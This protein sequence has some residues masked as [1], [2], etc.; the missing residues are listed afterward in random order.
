MAGSLPD[1]AQPHQ[2]PDFWPVSYPFNKD[3]QRM[4]LHRKEVEDVL[5]VRSD[6]GGDTGKQPSK[7]HHASDSRAASAW[8]LPGS[9]QPAKK[10]MFYPTN[11]Y[12]DHQLPSPLPETTAPNGCPFCD[13]PIVWMPSSGS[14]ATKSKEASAAR[15]RLGWL[16]AE[17]HQQKAT[18]Q[19]P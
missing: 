7:S 5:V 13:M 6:L 17:K 11:K 8:L 16:S 4:T 1:I 9:P 19:T 14:L 10:E 2:P 3:A 18:K 12:H 15:H